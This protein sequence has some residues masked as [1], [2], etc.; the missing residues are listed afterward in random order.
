MQHFDYLMRTVVDWVFRKKHPGL[1]LIR[2]G[3]TLLAATLSGLA[4]SLSFPLSKGPFRFSLNTD[5]AAGIAWVV[6]GVAIVL[7]VAGLLWLRADWKQIDRRRLFA[8][9]FRGLRDWN[10]AP[11]VDAIPKSAEGR[12]EEILVD[13]RQRVRDGVIV[14]PQA[15][16]DRLSGLR[17]DLDRREDGRA[18]T[19]INYYVGGLAPVPLSFL[20]G[21]YLDDE[22]PM[23]FMDWDRAGK[24]WRPLDAADDGVRFASHGLDLLSPGTSEIVLAV[25]ASYRVDL[26]AA[27][28]RV[29][30]LPLVHLELPAGTDGHWS[31][32]KQQALSKQ[33][34]DT[35][36]ALQA[37]GVRRI[38]LFFAG[39]NSLVLRFGSAYDKRNLPGLVVYQYEP[40][41]TPS[42]SWGV[43]MPVAGRA[44]PEIVT[45]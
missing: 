24:F 25:S 14:D 28:T 33:F 9:E 36:L 8:V 18:R 35:A 10:G 37:T 6:L 44:R 31:E 15:A 45:P 29:G 23:T 40:G 21:I 5:G 19:D 38:H 11:L 17:A 43:E 3:S 7:I 41:P 12:R 22:A 32:A 4:I 2:I 39:A 26:Q 16:V 42:F 13:L 20:A 30:S 34:H 1:T 27:A